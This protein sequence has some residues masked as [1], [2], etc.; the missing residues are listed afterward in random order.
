MADKICIIGSGVVGLSTGIEFL[1]TYGNKIQV[2]IFS[3]DDFE[4]ACSSKAGAHWFP[5]FESTDLKKFM[6]T[7][8]F[9]RFEELHKKV[10]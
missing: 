9:K 6:E 4:D 2:I 7:Y 1:E 3:K 5:T 8:T 10:I